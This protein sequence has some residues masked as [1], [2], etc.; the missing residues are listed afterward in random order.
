MYIPMKN[1]NVEKYIDLLHPILSL[2]YSSN[3]NAEREDSTPTPNVIIMM[4]AIG[5]FLAD[6]PALIALSI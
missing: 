3:S 4:N 2:A 1:E 6:S 5:V